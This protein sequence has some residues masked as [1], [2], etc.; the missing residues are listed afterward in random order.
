MPNQLATS[1]R[2][3][4]NIC[5]AKSA[6]TTHVSVILPT[7]VSV[8]IYDIKLLHI[9]RIVEQIGPN[10]VEHCQQPIYYLTFQYGLLD[11]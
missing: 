5:L 2:H 1:F 3:I 9:F 6:H 10:Y 4:E 7:L 8:L 11:S